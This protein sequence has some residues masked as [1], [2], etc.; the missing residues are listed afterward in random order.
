[1]VDSI[2][3]KADAVAEAAWVKLSA[4]VGMILVS[5]FVPIF[6]YISSAWIDNFKEV[7]SDLKLQTARNTIELASVHSAL[8]VL[9][10]TIAEARAAAAL[11][12]SQR[13][14][15]IQDLRQDI[16]EV[17]RFLRDRPYSPQR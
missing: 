15:L 6:M 2:T 12:N 14:S 8:D 13:D 16:A 9:S 10:A 11:R 5:G 1:M 17:Q 3:K 4:R 7:I